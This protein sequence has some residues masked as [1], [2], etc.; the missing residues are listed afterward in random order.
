MVT[1]SS[2][3]SA[4]EEHLGRF[5]F[6]TGAPITR[7]SAGELCPPL[8]RDIG[9]EAM[10]LFLRG[11]LHRL[12]GPLSPITYLR[13]ADYL[14]PYI[15]YGR[16]GR[17][18]LLRPRE[19]TPWHAGIDEVYVASRGTMIDPDTMVFIPADIP[20]SV[21][22][23][24]FAMVTQRRELADAIH[25]SLY[26]A[27]IADT[28]ERLETIERTHR[29]TERLSAPLRKLFQ[30]AQQRD[31]DDAVRCMEKAGLSESDLC[32]A[33]HHLPDER[34]EYITAAYLTIAEALL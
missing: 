6:H 23:E 26:Q 4:T 5:R 28:L 25:P 15:D 30:S 29:E 19:V 27:M 2:T 14:E 11:H 21:A 9:P 34:R 32:T 33:W 7:L 24:Q 17:I 18:M 16:I 31:R 20:L 3:A 22:A 8:F 13:T 10:G 12:C 1:H